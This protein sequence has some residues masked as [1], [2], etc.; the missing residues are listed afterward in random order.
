MD[1]Q[2]S[3]K[4]NIIGFAVGA[5]AFALTYYGVQQIFKP[6]MEKE[7]KKVAVEINKQSP[8]QVDQLTRLDSA[9]SK[10]KTNLIYYYTL[11]ETER[12]EVNFDTVNKY[13]RS[14]IIESLKINPDVKVFRDNNITLDYNYFDRNGEFVTEISVTPEMYN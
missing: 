13:I 5:I 1:K 9:S 7:L 4:G 10:G 6:D 2:A 8:I 11:L 3:K 14:G 12:S